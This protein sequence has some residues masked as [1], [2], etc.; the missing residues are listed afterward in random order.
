VWWSAAATVAVAPVL[1]LAVGDLVER[2]VADHGA[3]DRAAGP[4]GGAAAVVHLDLAD[5][6][7]RVSAAVVVSDVSLRVDGAAAR[8]TTTDVD[9]GSAGLGLGGLDRG[10]GRESG[11]EQCDDVFHVHDRSFPGSHASTAGRSEIFTGSSKIFPGTCGRAGMDVG[12]G[13]ASTQEPAGLPSWLD[14]DQELLG[15]TS[16]RPGGQRCLAGDGEVMLI[17]HEVPE[18]RVPERKARFYIRREDGTWDDGSGGGLGSLGGLLDDYQ[19]TIDRYEDEIDEADTAAE[20]FGLIRH[21]GPIARSARNLVAVLSRAVEICRDDR[22]LIEL[23][24]RSYE[25]QRAAELLYH[26]A[27]LTLE[28]WQAESAEDH[29]AAAER[30]NVI[31]YRL[32]LLAGFFLPVVAL[33]GLLGMN[34]EIPAI[35]HNAF[36]IILLTGVV[37]GMGLLGFASWRLRSWRK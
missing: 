7:N 13:M 29:Q 10:E 28:F 2:D 23:R 27:R 20:V 22:V 26:D 3:D 12:W 25:I 17:V 37:L 9:P 8:S 6:V 30:L 31:A 1:G 18:S 4:D 24:D 5:V 15:Q 16:N 33:G 11:G 36:W 14:L 34:V 21:A 32:N 19:V 35:F